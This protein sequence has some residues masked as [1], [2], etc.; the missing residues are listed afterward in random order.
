MESYSRQTRTHPLVRLRERYIVDHDTGCWVW[1][2]I[3]DKLG[4]GN[5]GFH[6]RKHTA[7]RASY[8][9]LIGDIPEG[10]DV[11]HLCRNPSCVNPSHLEPVTRSENI[12]RGFSHERAK[13]HCP[14]G[15]PYS[16]ENL[17]VLS[18][19]HRRCRTCMAA[20]RK[21][22]KKKQKVLA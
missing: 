6:G 10:L 9:L 11:D 2:G 19:G 3:K 18:T 16:G 20:H 13:T 8:L 12:R 17:A 15:H 21:A 14:Q 22:W 5:F 4:Y 7:H 1:T